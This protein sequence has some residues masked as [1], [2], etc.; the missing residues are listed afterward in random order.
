MNFTGKDRHEKAIY[1]YELYFLINMSKEVFL[2][3]PCFL[4]LDPPIKVCGY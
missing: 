2:A 4:E 3:Q 1:D